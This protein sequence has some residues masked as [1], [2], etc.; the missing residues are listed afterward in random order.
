MNSSPQPCSLSEYTQQFKK[1]SVRPRK[2]ITPKQKPINRDVQMVC[3]TT[4][5]EDFTPHPVTPRTQPPPAEHKQ[6]EGFIS[7]A[8]E[9]REEFEEKFTL[10]AV[11]I[12]PKS[13]KKEL[14][15]PFNHKSTQAVDF[16][17][18]SI[19]PRESFAVKRVYEPPKEH[20]ETKST[21]R[22]DF[23]D[24]GQFERT[25]SF[26]P[27]Q[28]PKLSTDP[29][30]ATSYYRQ[31]FTPQ[32]I[33]KRYQPPKKEYKRSE[34]P[35][36]G[37][38]TYIKDFPIYKEA[39]PAQSL[40]PMPKPVSCD[41]PFDSQ[42]TS[43]LSYRSWELPPKFTHPATIYTPPTEKLATQSTFKADFPDYGQVELTRA[44]RPLPRE[45]DATTSF[46]KLTTQK[47]DFP[48]LNPS[49]IQRASLI[50]QGKNYEPPKDRFDC[51]S[52]F[53]DHFK[54]TPGIRAVST[55]PSAQP[56]TS[57]EKMDCST[58]YQQNF[59][60]SG[61]KPCPVV[62]ISKDAEACTGYKFS[63]Q[64]ERTGHMFFTPPMSAATA[65]QI[66][67]PVSV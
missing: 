15:Q 56:Y 66:V 5:R 25:V 1:Y 37:P 9:Y 47:A 31:T 26:K 57:A 62:N 19:T 28:T 35:L 33:P 45:K 63:Y 49:Q 54:G 21:A 67:D 65:T 42:T 17:P 4:S 38:S 46:E 22:R 23:V 51:L 7:S 39:A 41:I 14:G 50:S 20:I 3:T 53:Q 8:T 44:I 58:M 18:F 55:K 60:R 27:P 64:N 6:P 59:S 61:F 11:I 2:A 12:C 34:A 10:P 40:K 52:T 24:L 29:F 43:R 48:Q 13:A 30:D 16:I 32:S 36:S